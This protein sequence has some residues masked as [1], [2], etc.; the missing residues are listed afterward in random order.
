MSFSKI[1]NSKTDY[2]P[3]KRRRC[4]LALEGEQLALINSSF[5]DDSTSDITVAGTFEHFLSTQVLYFD[6][7][8]APYFIKLI[9]HL[10]IHQRCNLLQVYHIILIKASPTDRVC[11]RNGDFFELVIL[12]L[13][14][15]EK[16]VDSAALA[17]AHMSKTRGDGGRDI[18]GKKRHCNV[19]CECKNW[20][21]SVG[22]NV[23]KKLYRVDSTSVKWAIAF[24]SFN[25][26]AVSHAKKLNVRLLDK[27]AILAMLARNP[28]IC[29]NVL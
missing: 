21:S 18:I 4:T 5:L 19:I 22:K 17:G 24:G 9:R 7:G 27:R 15:A 26:P 23:I 25:A 20:C 16:I 11:H 13:L 8:D 3:R 29:K 1:F 28:L 14:L 6:P 2:N 12:Q 10:P